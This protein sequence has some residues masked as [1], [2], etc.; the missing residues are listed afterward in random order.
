MDAK[1][2]ANAA[3]VLQRAETRLKDLT[4]KAEANINTAVEEA[5][6]KATEKYN[7]K[8]TEATAKV[9]AA[10]AALQTLTTEA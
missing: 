10:K 9:A 7:G 3:Y 8:L 6:K 2:I 4:D 1:G 5:K